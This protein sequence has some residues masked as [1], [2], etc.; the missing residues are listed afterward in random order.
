MKLP[1]PCL[2]HI[3]IG[4]LQIKLGGA[5]RRRGGRLHGRSV[6]YFF[7]RFTLA[8]LY[9]YVSTAMYVYPHFIF[10][11]EVLQVNEILLFLICFATR[12]RVESC[13]YADTCQRCIIPCCVRR[14]KMYL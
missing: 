5:S 4:L 9:I 10:F 3:F 7:C 6:F 11:L 2:C 8:S 14:Y 1:V 12:P 13:T